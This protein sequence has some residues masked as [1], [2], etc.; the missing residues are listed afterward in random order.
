MNI[1]LIL[2]G[3]AASAV[4]CVTPATHATP[5]DLYVSDSVDGTIVKFSPGG[6]GSTFASGLNTPEGLALTGRG[7]FTRQTEV[8]LQFSSLHLAGR[9]PPS[10][11]D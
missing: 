6:T 8:V 9:K 5:S 3:V 2:S 11:P 1:R 10:R 7:I 4:L